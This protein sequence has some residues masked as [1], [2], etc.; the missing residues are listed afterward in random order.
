[1]YLLNASIRFR[2]GVIV[3]VPV[4]I[5]QSDDDPIVVVVVIRSP[6]PQIV[7]RNEVRLY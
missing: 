7:T 5:R 4:A 6:R 2:V 1:M 3:V